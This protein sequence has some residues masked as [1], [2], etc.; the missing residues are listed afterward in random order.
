MASIMPYLSHHFKLIRIVTFPSIQAVQSFYCS[1]HLGCSEYPT[2]VH[3]S[4]FYG[5]ERMTWALLEIP[6]GEAA[7]NRPNRNGHTPSVL[8]YQNGFHQLAHSLEDA[9]VSDCLLYAW[10]LQ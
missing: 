7:L 2:W 1:L 6:G 9:A 3:F 8:A 5:L 10:V 4:A